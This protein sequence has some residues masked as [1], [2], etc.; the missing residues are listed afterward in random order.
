MK[1]IIS[2]FLLIS[3]FSN[4]A[5]AD[6]DWSLIK[7][8]QDGSYTYSKELHVCVGNLIQTNKV[9]AAQ[10]DDLTKA[11]QLKD[12]AITKSDERVNVWMNSSLKLED[13]L[14]KVQSFQAGNS[15]LWFGLGVAAT[16]LSVFV[17]AKALGH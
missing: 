11:I 12:L 7:S 1:K 8:N 16:V 13:S 5:F 3:L 15:A 4:F 2:L 14:T 9:L 17:T 6:C 10:V